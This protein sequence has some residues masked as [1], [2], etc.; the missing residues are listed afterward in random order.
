MRAQVDAVGIGSET[1]LVDDPLLTAREVYRER[2]LTRVI[3][4]RRLRTPLTA[5]VFTDAAPVVVVTT[6]EAVARAPRQAGELQHAGARLL[7]VG[8]DIESAL[9][10]LGDSG[11]QSLLLEGGAGIHAAGWDAGVVDY[12]Q[13][14][15]APAWLG[16][17]GVPMP[18][19]VDAS[20]ATL[21]DR[22][23]EQ[24]GPD[25]LI[26]GYVHRPD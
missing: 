23:V 24:L 14:Y 4:D 15:V 1:L 20:L 12:V 22:R 3:F 18:A 19:A 2:P 9:R 10:A 25:V 21:F 5:R 17:S 26:E 13:V 16:A 7:P 6:P 8:P 11:I